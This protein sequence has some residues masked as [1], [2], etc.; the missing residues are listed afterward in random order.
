[1]GGGQKQIASLYINNNGSNKGLSNA[2]GNIN[3]TSKEIFT[4]VKKY[5]YRIYPVN[6]WIQKSESFSD[7]NPYIFTLRDN[8]Y[9]GWEN[10]S[11]N[12]STGIFT[13]VNKITLEWNDSS[14]T[15]SISNTPFYARCKYDNNINHTVTKVTSYSYDS[16]ARD[17]Y[18]TYGTFYYAYPTGYNSSL[19]N[20]ISSSYKYD[21]YNYSNSMNGTLYAISES[22]VDSGYRCFYA[23]MSGY[24]PRI[25]DGY[26]AEYL[27][28]YI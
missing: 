8:D 17:N 3:G 15:S 5:W 7:T 22:G 2:Y 20:I 27:G 16:A 23:Q 6:S 12:S 25:Y 24:Y 28:Y 1:M 9:N 26:Y 19:Y 14:D 11:Y 4:G 21:Y 18:S 13:L 10:Y